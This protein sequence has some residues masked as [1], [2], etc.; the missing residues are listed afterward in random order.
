MQPYATAWHSLTT[1]LGV[2]P[3]ET[4][5]V[6]GAAGSIGSAVV[7]M[8]RLAGAKVLAAIGSDRRLEVVTSS[9]VPSA[10]VINY[11]THNL[12]EEAR[13]LTEGRGVDAVMEIVGGDIFSASLE[14][15]APD[16]RLCVIGAH[17]GE[18]VSLDLVE[19]FRRQ[20]KV[21]GSSAYTYDDVRKIFE[22]M[23]SGMLEPPPYE[24]MPLAEAAEAHRRIG[25][26]EN[27]GKIVLIP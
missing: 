10:Q 22:L 21:Y 3:G 20:I 13:R 2:A 8:V 11:S 12:A 25:A 5:L 7:R 6:T 19:I 24:T 26:R 27:L 16:G 17:G 15:L 14:A 9:G 1:L 23:S 18:K 4:V